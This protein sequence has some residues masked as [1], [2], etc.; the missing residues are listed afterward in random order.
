VE[1]I[2][3]HGGNLIHLRKEL[4]ESPLGNCTHLDEI[5]TEAAPGL[6]LLGQCVLELLLRYQTGVEEL[7]GKYIVQERPPPVNE[8]SCS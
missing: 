5:V 1:I 7:I 2:E 3:L 6:T 4:G 8:L